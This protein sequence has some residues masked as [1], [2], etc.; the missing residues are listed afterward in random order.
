MQP[1]NNEIA[2]PRL[3]SIKVVSVGLIDSKDGKKLH[4]NFDHAGLVPD[5]R[6]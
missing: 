3:M 4:P 6:N 1:L 2:L 5:V